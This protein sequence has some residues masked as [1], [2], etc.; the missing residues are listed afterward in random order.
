MK[1]IKRVSYTE[2]KNSL[3]KMVDDCEKACEGEDR[4]KQGISDLAEGTKNL[5]TLNLKA[6]ELLETLHTCLTLEDSEIDVYQV[7]VWFITT[8]YKCQIFKRGKNIRI[9]TVQIINKDLRY[10]FFG[11]DLDSRTYSVIETK[12]KKA[13]EEGRAC[14]IN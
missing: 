5:F 10:N 2:I 14:K 12:A 7:E 8:L 4:F 3:N 11:K 1:E 9:S 13:I 6:T